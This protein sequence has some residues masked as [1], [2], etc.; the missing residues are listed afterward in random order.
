MGKI[1]LRIPDT[2]KFSDLKL[3]FDDGDLSFD[4][5][6]IEIICGHNGMPVDMFKHEP[7]DNVSTLIVHWYAQHREAGGDPDPIAEEFFAEIEAEGLSGL[8]ALSAPRPDQ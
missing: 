7:E 1:Q 3:A 6:P 8:I 4:W 5:T 2:V